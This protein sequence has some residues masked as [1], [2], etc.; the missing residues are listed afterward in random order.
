MCVA[1]VV[2]ITC[3]VIVCVCVCACVCMCVCV[4]KLVNALLYIVHTC[5]G[6][7]DPIHSNL[8]QV[9]AFFSV[10]SR[11]MVP[12]PPKLLDDPS[13]TLV[14]MFLHKVEFFSVLLVCKG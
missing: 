14:A 6:M 13:F 8:D 12:L 5:I 10:M 4:Y 1:C 7:E 9:H 11:N 3:G 2:C